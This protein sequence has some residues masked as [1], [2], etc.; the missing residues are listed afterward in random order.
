MFNFI[1][2]AGLAFF[3]LS[4]GYFYLKAQGQKGLNTAFLVSFLTLISYAL[5]WQGSL[6]VVTEA[7]EPIYWT[8]WIFYALSCTLLILEIA[9]VKGIQGGTLVESI[10]LTA[11]V[12][13]TGFLAARDLSAFRWIYLIIS[14][15][16]YGLLLLKVLPGQSPAK[17]VNRYILFGW[18]VF[19]IV[20]VFAPTGFGLI[21]AAAANLLY[22]GLDLYT[23]IVFNLQLAR[24]GREEI[25]TN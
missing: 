25:P 24:S 14:T 19:P 8:R 13:L 9:R 1:F 20:F 3:T 18:T 5:M 22:L 23:K 16:A 12:M 6:T 11:I 7:G 21:G 4:S 10:Y 17:W 2:A 15:I